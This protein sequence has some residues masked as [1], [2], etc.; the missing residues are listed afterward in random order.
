MELNINNVSKTI[1]LLLW[2]F[3]ITIVTYIFI[4]G[5]IEYFRIVYRNF[6]IFNKENLTIEEIQ[7]DKASSDDL[8]DLSG[9]IIKEDKSVD[10]SENVIEKESSVD[11]TDLSGNIII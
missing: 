3:V 4:L 7:I 6:K 1:E 5:I 11:L 2:L 9:N 8:T 10:L